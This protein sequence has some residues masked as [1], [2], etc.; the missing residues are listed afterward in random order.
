[1]H[2][3]MQEQEDMT[4]R[5]ELRRSQ[6]SK[7]SPTS[8]DAGAARFFRSPST[9]AAAVTQP[10]VPFSCTAATAAQ[11]SPSSSSPGLTAASSLTP[12][13]VAQ[14]GAAQPSLCSSS[15]IASFFVP[16]M[17]ASAAAAD[18]A[19]ASR[20]ASTP[21]SET[22]ASPTA[23]LQANA[24]EVPSPSSSSA[25]DVGADVASLASPCAAAAPAA[26][27][28]QQDASVTA[29]IA[30]QPESVSVSIAAPAQACAD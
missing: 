5:K 18:D 10:T 16:S 23:L 30:L 27:P 17:F 22:A 11:T 29:D 21:L 14:T 12:W 8:S 9:S 4:R 15:A 13:L 24:D 6:T 26:V 1:V 25:A 20:G 19:T 7:A 2:A 3:L 28:L